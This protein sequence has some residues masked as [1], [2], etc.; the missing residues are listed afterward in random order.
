[1]TE[2]FAHVP[3]KEKPVRF[4]MKQHQTV[5]DMKTQVSQVSGISAAKLRFIV[6]GSYG[7]DCKIK[8]LQVTKNSCVRW[9]QRAQNP[10]EIQIPKVNYK[11][12]NLPSNIAQT[13]DS[14]NFYVYCSGK[15]SNNCH[16]VRKI[17][18]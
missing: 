18:L 13:Y 2:L 6:D 8:D 10:T 5:R 14:H 4:V 12:P 15:D 7:D 1:M 9:V 16:D 3:G 11:Y 17:Q